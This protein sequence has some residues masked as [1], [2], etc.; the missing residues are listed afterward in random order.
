MASRLPRGK[1]PGP[2]YVPNE[3]A[4]ELARARPAILL[5]VFNKC[6]VTGIF[7]ARWKVARL[8]LLHKGNGKPLAE[9][10]SYR[11]LSLLDELSELFERLLLSRMTAHLDATSSLSDNQIGFR[12]GIS[13]SDALKCVIKQAERAGSGPARKRLLCAVVALDVTNAFNS[14]SWL[15]IDAVLRRPRVPRIPNSNSAVIYE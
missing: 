14:A 13:T 12:R 8:V 1:A 10:S 5:N 7:P 3:V 6:L 11:P 4:T 9:S 2:E 15:L